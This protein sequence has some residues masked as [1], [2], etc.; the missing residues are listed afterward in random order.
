MGNF[1]YADIHCHPTLKS[2][3]HSFDI[4]KNPKSD[5]WHQLPPSFIT[6]KIHWLTGVSK[7][8]QANFTTLAKA[9]AKIII[10]SLYP[11]EKGFFVT[12]HLTSQMLALFA[13]W[14]IAI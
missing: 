6:K 12:S 7:F 11:L 14:A 3:G 1:R 13:D 2:F 9:K 10:V 8:S 5:M 4:R